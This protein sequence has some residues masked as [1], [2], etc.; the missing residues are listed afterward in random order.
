MVWKTALIAASLISAPANAQTSCQWY[1][2]I[3]RC[4][5]APTAPPPATGAMWNNY[6][7]GIEAQN[8][9]TLESQRDRQQ[10]FEAQ[11]QTMATT[12]LRQRVAGEIRAGRCQAAID[13][14]LSAGD[15]ELAAQTKSICQG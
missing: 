6:I 15:V 1:G 13:M 3:W 11:S 9:R 4:D 5:A 7:K 14:A 2:S 12:A 10:Q 8:Q